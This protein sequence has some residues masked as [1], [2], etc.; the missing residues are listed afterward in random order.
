M[1][2][3]AVSLGRTLKLTTPGVAGSKT[4]E[5]SKAQILPKVPVAVLKSFVLVIDEE[6]NGVVRVDVLRMESRKLSRG[7]PERLDGP[8]VFV[9]A[10]KV[11]EESVADAK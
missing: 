4:A 8:Q 6:M 3:R 7:V 5:L 1:R 11:S 10:I 2:A 9:L